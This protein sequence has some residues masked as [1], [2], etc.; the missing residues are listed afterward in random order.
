MRRIFRNATPRTAMVLA[1]AA[2][3][4]S[5]GCSLP[6]SPNSS[7][8]KMVTS[9]KDPTTTISSS[10]IKKILFIALVK[11]DPYS[12]MMENHLVAASNGK[13]IAS[14]TII[15]GRATTEKDKAALEQRIKSDQ[16]DLVVI[17]RLKD[18]KEEP[19]YVADTQTYG[20]YG[21]MGVGYWGYYNYAAPIYRTPGFYTSDKHFLVET[22]V[23]SVAQSKLLWSGVTDSV[24]PS[25]TTTSRI[26]KA[27]VETMKREGFLVD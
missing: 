27:A 7:T 11:D 9:W 17:M 2:A 5:T 16:I 26:A 13:G 14:H 25:Y 20:P 21:G 8:T 18:V 15:S 4:F 10:R 12:E 3:C 22:N 24:N 1:L 23:Y 6:A 19:R